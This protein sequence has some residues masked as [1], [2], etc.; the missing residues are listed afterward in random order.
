MSQYNEAIEFEKIVMSLYQAI[1]NADGF[2]NIRVEHNV[3][4]ACKSGATAQFDIYWKFK[5]AGVTH[6]VAIECKNYNKKITSDKVRDFACK[7]HD[8]GNL[9]GIMVSRK[10]YQHGTK[11][12]AKDNRIHEGQN[13]YHVKGRGKTAKSA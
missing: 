4:L 6:E 1:L 12:I 7:L 3:T 8:A 10:G 11:L 2:E 13:L 9:R 5:Q